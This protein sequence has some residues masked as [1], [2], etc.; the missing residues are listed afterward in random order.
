MVA[1]LVL[2]GCS[3]GDGEGDAAP[4]ADGGKAGPSASATP[5]PLTYGERAV[6]RLSLR[7]AAGQVIVAQYAGT[8]S[9][10]PVVR[11]LHLGG[12]IAFSDN[13]SSTG[14]IRR[15]NRS[16]G[17][18]VAARGWPAFVGVDQEGGIVDRVG[19]PSTDFPSFMAA[20]AAALP[21]TTERAARAGAAEMRGLGFDV[22]LAP[23]AD[24]TVGDGD[25][26]IGSRS[27]GGRP[28]E[29]AT[30]VVA[31]MRGI[32]G[33]GVLPVLKHFPGHGSLGADSHAD[34]P[35][36]GKSVR[37]LRRSDLVPFTAAI[38]ARAPAVLT[39]HIAVSSVDKGVP[40]SISRKVTTGLLRRDLGFDGLVVTDALDMAG[41]QQR[42]PGARAAVRALR[43][44]A[45]VLLM[46]PDPRA[47]RDAIVHA[48][49][50]GDLPRTRLDEAAA[51]MIDTLRS[52]HAGRGAR[53]GSARPAA[54]ALARQSVTSVAG[55]CRGR[56][57]PRRV[58]VVG[59]PGDVAAFDARMAA[60]GVT[61]A[62]D[63]TRRV[64]HGSRLVVVG[65]KRRLVEVRKRVHG[66][67]RVVKVRERVAVR[68]RRPV[69]RNVRVLADAPTV[70]LVA[71]GGAVPGPV[72]GAADITVALDRPS[73]LGRV[74]SRVEL[75]TYGDEPVALDALADVLMGTRSAPGHLPLDVPGVSRRG[76]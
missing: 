40:A 9:P 63:A 54:L 5:R 42:A 72:R 8:A 57:V 11:R 68:K 31:A 3:G 49:R 22:V 38:A 34:L 44:G 17:Q 51:R 41:V 37:A 58:R 33:A 62:H 27:A 70:A 23:D 30:Q 74:R 64:R 45:D 10:A 47:A 1:S 59:D 65:H 32:E 35:L 6:R 46:P 53:P 60:R 26:A 48:V 69:F 16:V 73:V 13:V 71:Y 12:V 24:V 4:K 55:P 20:G 36:Q 2:T 15:V 67:V 14:Q 52:V 21:T 19:A 43:A 39:G 56:L 29:V 75:A 28:R 18:V 7:E 76:C 50:S 25:A 66:V 61:I